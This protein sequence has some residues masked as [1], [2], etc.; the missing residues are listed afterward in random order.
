MEKDSDKVDFVPGIK[1]LFDGISTK[2]AE[3]FYQT[4]FTKTGV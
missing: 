2:D 1:D 3:E 4:R